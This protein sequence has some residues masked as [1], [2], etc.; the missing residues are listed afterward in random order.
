[1]AQASYMTKPRR[2]HGVRGRLPRALGIGNQ[3]L[4][5]AS[6]AHKLGDGRDGGGLE[7]G[8]TADGQHAQRSAAREEQALTQRVGADRA[9]VLLPYVHERVPRDET[10]ALVT[11]NPLMLSIVASVFELR[12]GIDMPRTVVELYATASEA[13]QRDKG[14]IPEVGSNM[15]NGVKAVAPDAYDGALGMSTRALNS[16]MPELKAALY[17]E[18]AIALSDGTEFGGERLGRF[19]A[20]VPE[21]VFGGVGS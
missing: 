9:A 8:P 7:A 17:C 2:A 21:V 18:G 4:D 16:S 14:A 19:G 20:D 5:L 6:I 13:M 11:A 10:G 1:M 15:G 12:Q 3:H